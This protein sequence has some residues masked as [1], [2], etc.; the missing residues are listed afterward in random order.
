[1]TD[2]LAQ[3]RKDNFISSELFILAALKEES[4]LGRILKQAGC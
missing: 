1:M 4:S 2:K 3:Q